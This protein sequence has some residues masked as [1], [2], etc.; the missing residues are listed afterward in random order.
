MGWGSDCATWVA[1]SGELLIVD[2]LLSPNPVP[3][4]RTVAV[5]TPA[6]TA[7]SASPRHVN[8]KTVRMFIPFSL[9]I[10]LHAKRANHIWREEVVALRN[11]D[12]TAKH[13]V[14]GD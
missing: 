2:G 7:S 3:W 14:V 13:D 11:D 1:T 5:V 12:R 6:V 9:E 4:S 8:E 10:V